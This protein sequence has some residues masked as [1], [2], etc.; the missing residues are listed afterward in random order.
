MDEIY[1][2]AIN[3]IPNGGRFIAA[4]Y[5]SNPERRCSP[6]EAY[7]KTMAQMQHMVN[8]SPQDYLKA[9]TS[10]YL[11]RHYG[12]PAQDMRGYD[13]HTG[14]GSIT[15]QPLGE[16]SISFNGW[17]NRLGL[18]KG[19]TTLSQT[20]DLR[21][22][23]Q[24]SQ[25]ELAQRLDEHNRWLSDRKQILSSAKELFQLDEAKL[26]EF[27][28]TM[29]AARLDLS[30]CEI[31]NMDFRGQNLDGVNFRNARLEGCAFS[32]AQ[33]ADF[34]GA[35]FE[36]CQ[37][38]DGNLSFS[39]FRQ[40]RQ[41]DVR[42]ENCVMQHTDF[43][44]AQM[45]QVTFSSCDLRAAIFDGIDPRTL[46]FEQSDQTAQATASQPIQKE[47]PQEQQQAQ[48]PIQQQ[49]QTPVQQQGGIPVRVAEPVMQMQQQ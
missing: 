49:T 16:Q 45:K 3:M 31:K 34:S 28:K 21:G 40:S 2:D 48:V 15:L 29:P 18:G 7:E 33:G 23:N 4:T 17:L 47:H 13:F 10:G 8:G 32:D 43:T 9:A 38:A 39:D 20:G 19:Q 26:A 35:A 27:L 11:Q 24:I 12:F 30:G 36:R 42:F 25:G 44:D 37:F 46:R 14:R 5:T 22:Y 6:K 41:N 1:N